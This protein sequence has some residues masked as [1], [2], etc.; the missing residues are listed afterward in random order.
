MLR[1][2]KKHMEEGAQIDEISR[3]T[4]KSYVKKADRQANNLERKVERNKDKPGEY[5]K[6]YKRIEGA[7]L[8]RDKM[9]VRVAANEELSPK[10]KSLAALGS[11]KDKITKKDVLIGRGVLPKEKMEEKK[12]WEGSGVSG[13]DPGMEVAKQAGAAQQSQ[14]PTKTPTKT[15]NA[16]G[17]TISNAR[18]AAGMNEAQ[19]DELKAPTGKTAMQ[20]YRRAERSDDETGDYSRSSRIYKSMKKRYPGKSGRVQKDTGKADLPD[21]GNVDFH[22][23][24]Y[25]GHVSKSGKLTKAASRETKDDI[26]SRLGKHTKPHLPEEAQLDELTGKGKLPHMKAI[27]Q[28]AKNKIGRAHV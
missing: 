18:S 6:M 8:A 2:R 1:D 20:A 4:L 17:S 11:P 21:F 28:D 24:G 26:K 9:K 10:E 3:T 14:T 5:E 25:S 12:M 22:K 13:E 19:L 16:A 23:A 27:Y 15:G 7:N